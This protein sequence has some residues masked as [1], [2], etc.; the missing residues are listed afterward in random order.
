MFLPRTWLS[1]MSEVQFKQIASQFYYNYV[2]GDG[3]II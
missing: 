3:E 2:L 1:K